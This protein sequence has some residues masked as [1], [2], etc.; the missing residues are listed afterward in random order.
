[1]A[2]RE[3][4]RVAVSYLKDAYGADEFICNIG[5]TG[6]LEKYGKKGLEDMLTLADNRDFSPLSSGAGRLFDAAAAIMGVGDRNTFEGEASMALESLTAD[7][8]DDAY[9]VDIHFGATIEVDFSSTIR[10]LVDDLRRKAG[11]SCM[12]TKF[13]NAVVSAIT[14]VV[15]KLALMN[16]IKVIALSGG[17][18]QN[19]YLTEKVVKR[20]LRENL[21]V[22]TNEHVPCND[23]GISLGQAYLARE[24]LKDG[25]LA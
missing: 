15:L 21:T 14:R 19:R 25:A 8:I 16:N 6:F 1:M 22:H 12:A 23:A 13:H 7:G 24:M 20:L 5:P 2:V 9:P 17:V 4:W 3:P 10:G 11:K 18:F